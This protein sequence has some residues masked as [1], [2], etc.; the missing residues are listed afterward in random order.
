MNE[1]IEVLRR[2]VAENPPNYSSDAHSILEMLFSYCHEC[3]NTDTDAVKIAFEDLYQQ[4]YGMPLREM[5]RN[6][7]AVC[8]LC[9]KHKRSEFIENLKSGIRLMQ[10]CT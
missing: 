5:D 8:T 4:M 3:N 9:R 2:Y 7:D 10:E 6:V 1:Y